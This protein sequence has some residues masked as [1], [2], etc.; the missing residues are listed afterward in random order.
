MK[1]LL[2]IA[3]VLVMIFAIAPMT[4]VSA[5]VIE[6]AQGF[7]LDADGVTATNCTVKRVNTNAYEGE[8]SYQAMLKTALWN[9]NGQYVSSTNLKNYV[10]IAI[11][12][13][14]NIVG[15]V[16]FYAY[17]TQYNGVKCE[18]WGV[19]LA[20]GTRYFTKFSQY[21]FNK[22]VWTNIN[23][24]GKTMYQYGA[25]SN[26]K[27]IAVEDFSGDNKIASLIVALAGTTDK[28][29]ETL[30]DNVYYE[31]DVAKSSYIVKIDGEQVAD[32]PFGELYTVQTPPAHYCYTD[33]KTYYYGGEQIE[34]KKDTE[35]YSE[36][37]KQQ[38]VFTMDPGSRMEAAATGN[39]GSGKEG[40]EYLDVNGDMKLAIKLKSDQSAY[41]KLPSDWSAKPYYKPISIKIN[42]DKSISGTVGF[43]QVDFSSSIAT[44]TNAPTGNVLNLFTSAGSLNYAPITYTIDVTEDI[45]DCS[46]FVAKLYTSSNWSE[47]NPTYVY[48]DNV[49]IT[50][51]YDF[52]YTPSINVTMVEG[53]GVRFN[54]VNGLR[55]RANVDKAA[56]QNF[57][58]NGYTVT[59]GTL[60]APADYYASYT[61]MTLDTDKRILNVVTTSFYNEE[62]GTIAGSI[63][64]IKDENIGRN[65][66]ARAYVMVEKDGETLVFYADDNDNTRS[67]KQVSISALE[68]DTADYTQE[69]RDFLDT[70][71]KANDWA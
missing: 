30:I 44:G 11:P 22:N 70:W 59:M 63:G 3:L 12:D 32:V 49:T 64:K 62:A 51:E 61:D 43:K 14:A 9:Q 69:Q 7:E 2:S 41:F 25:T 19:E 16:G 60:I 46:Y 55:F 57:V 27:V 36:V 24:I 65:F 66:I 48:V 58:A 52:N 4:Y 40:A 23:F 6:I 26:T 20:D 35:L 67:L 28:G 33:G 31:T 47:S 13:S 50:Y 8:Y 21:A 53:A 56:L 38:T 37:E 18:A 68:D 1:K 45:Y 17:K 10:K 5:S 39:I 15:N 42:L 54:E 71:S 29:Y 34:L